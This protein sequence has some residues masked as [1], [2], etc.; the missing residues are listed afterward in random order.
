MVDLAIPSFL[1]DPPLHPYGWHRDALLRR[2]LADL[3]GTQSTDH[4]SF[5]QTMQRLAVRLGVTERAIDNVLE[6]ALF[7]SWL[8]RQLLYF[9]P[10][11]QEVEARLR[12]IRLA[13]ITHR[14]LR[15]HGV[16][17]SYAFIFVDKAC[18]TIACI[19][20]NRGPATRR[21]GEQSIAAAIARI[22]VPRCDK[23]IREWVAWNLTWKAMVSRNPVLELR[24]RM[25]EIFENHMHNSWEGDEV[26]IDA[27]A[28]RGVRDPMPF[29]DHYGLLTQAYYARLCELRELCDGWW[30][31]RDDIGAIVYVPRVKWNEISAKRP[32]D[33]AWRCAGLRRM[34]DARGM[35][36]IRRDDGSLRW[37]VPD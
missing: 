30:Y 33:L 12:F 27:W 11:P 28:K 16:R 34:T 20:G 9:D 2:W 17:P 22:E 24:E 31:W 32:V 8:K 19:S 4:Q 36:R 26:L 23:L 25:A 3:D 5:S 13:N 29:F 7:R 14:F 18:H 35:T 10:I 1:T 6:T 15:R 37:L 21:T